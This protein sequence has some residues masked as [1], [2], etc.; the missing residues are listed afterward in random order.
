MW[1]R[2]TFGVGA[3]LFCWGLLYAQK[4]FKQYNNTIEHNNFPLPPNWDSPAE[5]VFAR[6]KYRDVERYRNG[7]NFYWTMDYPAGD[8]HLIEGVRRLTRVNVRPVEQVIELDG[9]DDVYNWPF[10][11]GV[12][13]GRWELDDEEA[14]QL[15]GFLLRGGFLLVD[16]FHGGSEW[17]TFELGMSLVFP[18]R[19]IVELEDKDQIFH[20]FTDIDNRVQ[21]P[22][23]QY[24]N[25]GLTY[26]R[27]DG[28]P[29]HWR[30]IL[31]DDGRVMVAICHNMDLGDAVEWSDNP[32]YPEEFASLAHRILTNY[33]VYDLTH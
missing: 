1:L 28:Y 13:V 27:P 15:R 11:Y 4:P 7:D 19:P 24:L 14:K 6:L 30:G 12:E 23:A 21:I 25:T 26:E 9:T 8:R 18:D 16:D 2:G 29:A 20:V 33:V 32:R 31:D 5:W 10:L 17:D 3:V 22:S